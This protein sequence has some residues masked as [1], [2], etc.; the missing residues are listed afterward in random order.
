MTEQIGS[1]TAQGLVEYLG[2]LV[3]KGRATPGAIR[4]LRTT[5]TKIMSTVDGEGWGKANIRDINVEDYMLRFANLTMGAYNDASLSVY[6]SR[7]KKV[8][9]W[10]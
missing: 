2:S 6:K 8:M 7:V 4:P 5:F 10:D 9:G 1:G 3:S